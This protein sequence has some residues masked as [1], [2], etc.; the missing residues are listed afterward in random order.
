VLI[1]GRKGW[2]D[3]ASTPK[4]VADVLTEAYGK[5]QAD[6]IQKTIRDCTAHLY[7]E[8]S[9]YRADLSYIAGK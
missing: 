5:E 6:A 9:T 7:T 1:N 3:F 8:A 2:A 4:S